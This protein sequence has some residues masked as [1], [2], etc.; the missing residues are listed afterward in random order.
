[1]ELNARDTDVASIFDEGLQAHNVGDLSAAEQLYQETLSIQP[2]HS[3]ANHNIG[4]VLAAKNE[5]D[6]ALKFFKYALDSNPNVSLFWASYIN[7]LI[8]LER[9]AESKTLVKAVKD[10]GIT[11][12]KIE[13]ISHRLEIQ[14]QEPGEKDT[15]ELDGL[16]ERQKFDD[17]IQKCLGLTDTYPRSATLNINLGKCYSELGQTEQA[18]TSYKKALDARPDWAEGHFIIGT[19]LEN[20]GELTA[21]LESYNNLLKIDPCAAAYNAIGM[22]LGEKGELEAS[23]KS[24]EKG[25]IMDKNSADLYNNLGN[26]QR[27]NRQLNAALDSYQ[28]ALSISPTHFGALN[29]MGITFSKLGNLDAAINSFQQ[30]IRFDPDNVGIQHTLNALTGEQKASAPNDYIKNLFDEYASSFDHNLVEILGYHTPKLITELIKKHQ[31]DISFGSILDLGCGTGLIGWEL[32]NLCQ[33]IQG[34]DLSKK[35]LSK[36]RQKNV[37]NKLNHT[38]VVEYLSEAS[39]DFDLFISADVF[40][41]VG[42]LSEVFRL[43]KSRNKRNG[44]FIFST[45]HT[46]KDGFF[47]DKSG[48]YSHSE[49]YIKMLCQEF[50]YQLKYFSKIDLRK[51]RDTYLTG[52]LYLLDF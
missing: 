22:I 49:S 38:G 42:D 6:K 27:N 32:R 19:I 26:S 46:E 10:A 4:M 29:N 51:H 9:I 25:I 37:Y 43:I 23:I 18:I 1:M 45:E 3:E 30:A 40:V 48:R 5:L 11:C 16:I 44:R 21:A 24:Y 28:K 17:A 33:N 47:L 39:L 13:E 8:K 31:S 15:Q 50:D 20:N 12:E 34:V 36:A 2:N 14:H 35:M 41:Y 52:G 7:V